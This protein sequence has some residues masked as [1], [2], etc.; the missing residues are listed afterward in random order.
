MKILV[1]D[2]DDLVRDMV[3]QML[4]RAGHLIQKVP[5][6]RRALEVLRVHG[7][8]LMITDIRM[9]GITGVELCRAAKGLH[10]GLPVIGM[11]GHATDDIADGLFDGFLQKPFGMD[12]LVETVGEVTDR[13]SWKAE[14]KS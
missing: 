8:H 5:N 12:E 14:M 10:P 6:G 2:D 13:R 3:G 4:T 7:P 11:S 1:V 9:P